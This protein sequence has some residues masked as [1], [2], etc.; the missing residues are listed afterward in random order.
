MV[1][2]GP[3]VAML[4]IADELPPTFIS[5][6]RTMLFR[7]LELCGWSITWI[8]RRSGYVLRKDKDTQRY[9]YN[10]KKK[11]YENLL[12]QLGRLVESVLER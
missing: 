3:Q 12:F 10:F 9:A 4:K 1:T 8:S 7:E 11:R 2:N 5:E 6:E